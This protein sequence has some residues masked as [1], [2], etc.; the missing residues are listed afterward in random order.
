MRMT[1]EEAV[2]HFGDHSLDFVFIDANHSYEAVRGDIRFWWPKVKPGGICAGHDY[3]DGEIAEGTFGV[4][5][6]VDEFV[7]SHQLTLFV[8]GE[9][10]PTWYVQKP[11]S[12]Q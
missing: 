9:K 4:K 2:K 5:K 10:W 3:L 6:A 11:L 7:Q 1:S 8:I 12:A